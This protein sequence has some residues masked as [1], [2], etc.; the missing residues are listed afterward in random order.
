MGCDM[1][2][3]ALRVFSNAEGAYGS[4]VNAL[5]DSGA[6]GDEDELADAYQARKSFAYGM[7][8]KARPRTQGFCRTRSRTS[9]SPTRT[10]NRSSWASPR[11]ITTSTRWAAFPAR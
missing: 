1:E 2:E 5:V 11:S 4:N 10:S 8:G 3:A 7:D 6:F 9:I